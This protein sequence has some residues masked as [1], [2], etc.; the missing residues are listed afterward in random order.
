MQKLYDKL[1]KYNIKDSI[2]F[3][4]KDRQFIALK[5]LEK[6]MENKNSYLA[7][8]ISNSLICY[9]LSWKGELYW[10]EF[11]QYFSSKSQLFSW[12]EN[13]SKQIIEE[14]W[15]FISNSKNNRRFTSMKHKRLEKLLP[16]LDDFIKKPEYF[17][18]NMEILLEKL[19]ETMNQKKD[20]KTI[21]FAIKMFWYAARNIYGFREF[22]KTIFI[23]I[24]SRLISIFNKYKE[25]YN[26]IKKFY[27]EL[28][29][30]LKIPLLHLDW[31]VWTKYE[32]LLS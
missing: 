25:N 23:P 4:E 12:Q 3:E 30:K 21:V 28:S 1:K 5:N 6:N 19:A 11:S 26:D 15:N 7:L 22:P 24:D 8:I 18:E 31:I 17:Y 14:L 16:F 27:L 9:Q 2:L 13:N 32:D 20:A 10:E 29:E